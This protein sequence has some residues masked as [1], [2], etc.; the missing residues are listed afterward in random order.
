MILPSKEQIDE[1][2]QPKVWDLGNKVRYDLCRNHFKH[3]KDF[4]TLTKVL[5]I[6]RIYAAAV[7][8]RRN[9]KDVINDHF[10]TDTI[11]PAFRNSELDDLLETLKEFKNLKAETI[12]PVLQTHFY[13]TTALSLITSLEKRSFSSKY[14]HFHLPNLFFIYDSRAVSGLR[15]F[16]SE[17]P[18][19][20][21]HLTRLDT[22]DNEYAKFFCKCFDLKRQI[23]D[24]YQTN[25]TNR[26]LDNLLIE[27]ANKKSIKK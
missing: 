16:T 2:C 24:V 4:Q 1:A 11:A 10:Y 19:D 12:Q 22:V 25:L 13:L 14:L 21:K 27:I 3:E 6:G 26:Q 20:L 8:R 15:S 18:K 23:A 9:K 7:E 5:F 17:V